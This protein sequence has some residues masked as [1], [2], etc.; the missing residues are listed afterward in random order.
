MTDS[1]K[2]ARLLR[3]LFGTVLCIGFLA[4]FAYSQTNKAT[5]SGSVTD[6]Q[7][8]V[9]GN[10]T[11]KVRNLAT[12]AERETTTSEEGFFEIPLLEIG[13]YSVSVTKQGFSTVKRDSVTLQT[14][15]ETRVDVQLQV[16]EVSNEVTITA[17]APLVQT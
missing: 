14:S 12:G 7:G 11:V 15:T 17:E 6:A 10:A 4:T 13:T 5:I 8:A 2:I 1:K 3:T 16:G 9:V